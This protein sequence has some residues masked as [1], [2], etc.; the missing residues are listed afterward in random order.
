MKLKPTGY[1]SG[2]P[3]APDKQRK[4]GPTVVIRNPGGFDL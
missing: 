3:A 4:H 2:R 1:S